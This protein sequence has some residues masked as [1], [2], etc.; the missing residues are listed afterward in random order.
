MIQYQEN[1][2]ST[3]DLTVETYCMF[4]LTLVFCKYFKFLE[5]LMTVT[6]VT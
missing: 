4:T 3:I 5:I 6:M 2:T 1:N